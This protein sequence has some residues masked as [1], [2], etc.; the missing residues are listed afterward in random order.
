MTK[1]LTLLLFIGLAYWGWVDLDKDKFLAKR[2]IEF[3]AVSLGIST[4]FWLNELSIENQ[5]EE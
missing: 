4:S 1:H 2:G 3:L 5:N